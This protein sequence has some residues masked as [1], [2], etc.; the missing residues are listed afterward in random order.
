[1]WNPKCGIKYTKVIGDSQKSTKNYLISNKAIDTLNNIL[2]LPKFRDIAQWLKEKANKK[3]YFPDL[4]VYDIENGKKVGYNIP[5]F[6][7]LDGINAQIEK[8]AALQPELFTESFNENQENGGK[9]PADIRES[10]H[11]IV[12]LSL[13]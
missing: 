2:D 3:G 8:K 12:L 4:L 9:L 6:K 5:A 13:K 7:K 1:M 11:L 10:W